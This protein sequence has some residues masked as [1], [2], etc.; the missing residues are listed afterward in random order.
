MATKETEKN[1]NSMYNALP[2]SLGG[3]EKPPSAIQIKALLPKVETLEKNKRGINENIQND[4]MNDAI[5][6]KV[7]YIEGRPP[8]ASASQ[9]DPTK[10]NRQNQKQKQQLKSVRHNPKRRR[11]NGNKIVLSAA[12]QKYD[13]YKPLLNLWIQYA[14]KLRRDDIASFPSRVTRMDLHGAPVDVIRSKDPGLVGI[15]G[16]LIAET[17][18]T[19]M[20]ITQKNK[21]VTVPKNVTVIRIKFDGVEVEILLPALAFRASERSARKIKKKH[22]PPI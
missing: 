11:P 6:H 19:V 10:P 7:L 15:S 3:T 18:N 4:E 5:R 16:I 22:M 13:I 1:A 20:I 8:K 17:A 21:A 9:N 2:K 12:E 14:T